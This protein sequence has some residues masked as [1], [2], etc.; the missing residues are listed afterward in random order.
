M[1]WCTK[2]VNITS[3]F[4]HTHHFPHHLQNATA[5]GVRVIGFWNLDFDTSQVLKRTIIPCIIYSISHCLTGYLSKKEWRRTPSI[6]LSFS[7]LF[8]IL[9]L[10]ICIQISTFWIKKMNRLQQLPP[11]STF[12]P[13]KK[14]GFSL[15]F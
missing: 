4:S 6:S 2:R 15:T 14:S 13:S 12:P 3:P 11:R 9:Y 10:L 8:F 7:I 1:N 5:S